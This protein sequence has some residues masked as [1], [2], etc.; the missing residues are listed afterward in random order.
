METP[1]IAKTVNEQDAYLQKIDAVANN[2]LSCLNG[3]DGHDV[4][5]VMAAIESR[6]P[7]YSVIHF[8]QS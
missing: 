1:Q 5:N 7:R 6:I 8:P 4:K 3:L 2:V